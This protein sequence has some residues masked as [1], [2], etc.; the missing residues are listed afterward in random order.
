MKN[1]TDI[2]VTILD[3]CKDI[4]PEDVL[5]LLKKGQQAPATVSIVGVPSNMNLLGQSHLEDIKLVVKFVAIISGI[6]I[7]KK[8]PI[9]N[10]KRPLE[11]R[12]T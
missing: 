8:C 10:Q 11:L 1:M 9:G 3:L 6:Q 5:K 2:E 7:H 4:S 12:N